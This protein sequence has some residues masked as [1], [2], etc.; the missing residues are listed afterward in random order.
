MWIPTK[1]YEALPAIYVSAGLLLL[2]G[3]V[4][5]GASHGLWLTYTVTGIVCALGG[6]LISSMRHSARTQAKSSE[7]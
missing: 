4:Y 3:S 2:L 5:I 7:V 1:I 6:G